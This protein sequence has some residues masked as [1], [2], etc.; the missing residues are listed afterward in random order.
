MTAAICYPAI[1][2]PAMKGE[3]MTFVISK[4]ALMLLSILSIILLMQSFSALAHPNEACG[5]VRNIVDG[6]TFD[7]AIQNTDQRMISN[8]ESVRIADVNSPEMATPDGPPAKDFASAVL[9]NKRVYLDID[10]KSGRDP[11]GRLVCVVYLAGVRGQPIINPCFNRMLVDSGYAEI[12]NFTDNEFNPSDWW[13]EHKSKNVPMPE[14]NNLV[15]GLERFAGDLLN[16]LSENQMSG[17]EM[18]KKQA[19]DWLHSQTSGRN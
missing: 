14:P 15:G 10:D 11:Y 6:D 18:L 19:E 2:H 12:D 3:T 16:R 7:V 17:L 5:V 1:Y 4:A 9:L 13:P 8:V